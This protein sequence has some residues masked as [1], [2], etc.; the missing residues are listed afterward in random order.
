M[1]SPTGNFK[2]KKELMAVGS[3][4]ILTP[5][6]AHLLFS[7]MGFTPTDEGFTLAL[8]R[9]IID[10]QVPHRD[11]ILGAPFF[12]PLLHVPFVLLGGN[13]TFWLSRMFVWFQLTCISW[14]WVSIINLLMKSPFSL[15]GKLCIS[16]IAFAATTHTKHLTAWPTI[17]GLFFIGMGTALCL[18]TSELSKLLGYFLLSIATLCKQNFVFVAPLSLLILGDW[19]QVRYWIA[20]AMP[21]FLYV[22]FL[23]LT[24]A[25]A[26][27]VLQLTSHR[28]L[29]LT[30]LQ[31]FLKLGTLLAALAGLLSFGSLRFNL[32]PA[33]RGFKVQRMVALSVLYC[34]PLLGTAL[35]LWFG[36]WMNTSFLVFGLLAGMAVW[37]FIDGKQSLGPRRAMLLVLLVAW[38][39]SLS[40]GYNSP[41][42][43]S[44]SILAV[45][46]A[47]VFSSYRDN[48]FLR[49]S[50][51]PAAVIV[52]F[53]FGIART[54]YIYREPPATNLTKSLADVLPG[55]K[56]IYTDANTYDF[57]SDLKGA[58]ELAQANDKQYAILP[59]VAAY[60]VKTK[61]KNSLP[62]AWPLNETLN[63]PLLMRRFI[64]AMEKGRGSTV[65]IVQKFQASTLAI[66]F[67]PLKDNE[68]AQYVRTHF[69]K[70]RETNYFELYE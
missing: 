16:L 64:E 26:D 70:S 24:R 11:F 50:L 53:S 7:W 62:A 5:L 58:V 23:L 54:R 51:A 38:T 39:A 21:G 69:K 27:A 52:L 34:A 56:L 22:L 48:R 68:V 8:S 33:S 17:D 1:K 14:L 19:K 40:G 18:R 3:F 29:L 66:G 57:M 9:R 37:Q 12:S 30:S 28:E 45:L 15:G 42:L 36:V 59:D 6:I 65:F 63:K 49:Y 44:G 35:S 10:G 46:A 13:Y 31:P 43:A 25:F 4:L 60:W 2:S 55:G 61:Q 32:T 41:A 47:A 67:I 20:A